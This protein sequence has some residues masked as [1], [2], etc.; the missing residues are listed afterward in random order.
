MD[1][2][3]SAKKSVKKGIFRDSISNEIHKNSYLSRQA[4]LVENRNK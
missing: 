1:P 4:F 3:E 2:V